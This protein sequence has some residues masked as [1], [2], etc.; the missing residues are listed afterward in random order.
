M[1]RKWRTPEPAKKKG[2]ERDWRSIP[3]MLRLA[4]PVLPAAPLQKLFY[5]DAAS[6]TLPL[7]QTNDKKKA[8]RKTSLKVF[9]RGCLKGTLSLADTRN[10]RKCEGGKGS[11]AQCNRIRNDPRR[12]GPLMAGR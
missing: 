4:L 12:G 7:A 9:R 5:V 8:D 6:A 1:A 3:L 2:G 10:R 11:C